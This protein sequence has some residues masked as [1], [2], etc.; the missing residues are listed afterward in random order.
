MQYVEGTLLHKKQVQTKKGGTLD[1]VSI[2][3][4][5]TSHSQVV[6]ITDFDG[7]INGIETGKRITVPVKCRAGVSERGNTYI[8]YV[9][10]GKPL[11]QG[12]S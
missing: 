10:A 6:D 5:Y 2:L 11:E 12:S 8:N 3:D 4:D 9:T 1:V 7:H